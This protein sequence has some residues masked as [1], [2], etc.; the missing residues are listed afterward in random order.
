MKSNFGTVTNTISFFLDDISLLV[1]RIAKL[2]R[3]PIRN[4]SDMLIAKAKK[5]FKLRQS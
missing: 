4:N 1:D 2:W 3:Q 5:K